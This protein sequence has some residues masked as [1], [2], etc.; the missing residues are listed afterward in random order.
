MRS[1]IPFSHHSNGCLAAIRLVAFDLDGTVLERGESIDGAFCQALHRAAAAGI[2]STTATGRPLDFQLELLRRHGLGE[3]AGVPHALIADERELFV[4]QDGA[5][6]P[7]AAWNE[8]IRAEWDKLV[9]PAL[10]LMVLVHARLL[11][12]GHEV[13]YMFDEAWARA[14]GNVSL[15]LTR[16]DVA[17][18]AVA[19]LEELVAHAGLP[20]AVNRNGTLVQ[21]YPASAGKGNVLRELAG[22]WGIT[23]AEVLAI[24]D[25]LNDLCMLDGRHGFGC[26]TVANA[27]PMIIEL[28]AAR[29]GH[30]SSA[31]CARGAL[32]ALEAILRPER[33]ALM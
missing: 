4:L 18:Q 28:V 25:S 5:Y 14:R 15:G 7:H 33:E 26:A 27:D 22:L 29:G 3:I 11:A 2:R 17:I 1:A 21:L 19:W 32:E 6:R 20:L 16:R 13:R 8:R 23:P 9:E 31:R 30:V 12:G 10:A 24:G